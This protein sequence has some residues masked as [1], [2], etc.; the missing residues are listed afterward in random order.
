M[1]RE[2]AQWKPEVAESTDAAARGGLLRSSGEQIMGFETVARPFP[3]V[4]ESTHLISAIWTH[5]GSGTT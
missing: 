3:Q 5:L 4:I 2:K 1:Q